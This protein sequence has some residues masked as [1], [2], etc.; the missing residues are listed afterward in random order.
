MDVVEGVGADGKPGHAPVR[1]LSVD[2]RLDSTAESWDMEVG[3][4]GI[5]A[6][7]EHRRISQRVSRA[8][9]AIKAQG[10]FTGCVAPFGWESVPNP[11]GPG[12]ALAP[13]G[14]ELISRLRCAYTCFAI[15]R[16]KA[17]GVACMA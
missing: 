10:R 7:E 3:M 2:D 15:P 12:R 5:C 13:V 9:R 6:K 11:N 8:K 4:H 1:F 17:E 14:E 16:K